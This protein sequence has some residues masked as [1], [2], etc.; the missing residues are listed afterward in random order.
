MRNLASISRP[1][2]FGKVNVAP[3]TDSGHKLLL[4]KHNNPV[5]KNEKSCVK[6]CMVR[7]FLE[8]LNFIRRNMIKIPAQRKWL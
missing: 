6:S 1:L 7:N 5:P 8:N 3:V 2:I 4:E